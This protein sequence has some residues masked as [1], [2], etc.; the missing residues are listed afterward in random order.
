MKQSEA[1]N[2]EKESYSQFLERVKGTCKAVIGLPQSQRAWTEERLSWFTISEHLPNEQSNL[3][4][5]FPNE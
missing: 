1:M 5:K 4:R 3:E 2:S